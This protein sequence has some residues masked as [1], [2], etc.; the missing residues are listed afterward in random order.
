MHINV[1]ALRQQ[2]WRAEKLYVEFFAYAKQIGC[3]VIHD[4]IESD[5][6]QAKLLAKWWQAKTDGAW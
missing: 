5:D 4:E 2:A 3:R 1:M 6:A